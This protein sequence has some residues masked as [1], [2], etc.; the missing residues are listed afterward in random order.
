MHEKSLH[1]YYFWYYYHRR[2]G[3]TLLVM[4]LV[5]SIPNRSFMEQEGDVPLLNLDLLEF[6][7]LFIT[8]VCSL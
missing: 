5:N 3:C 1:A 8:E 6:P 7:T 2:K 4:Q